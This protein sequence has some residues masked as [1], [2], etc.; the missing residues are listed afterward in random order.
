[1]VV[2]TDNGVLRRP[3]CPVNSSL[4]PPIKRA[5]YE[6]LCRSKTELKNI[7]PVLEIGFCHEHFMFV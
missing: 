5:V 3:V 7:T 6:D 1:M 2:K 4:V